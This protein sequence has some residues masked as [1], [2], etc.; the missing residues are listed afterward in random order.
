MSMIEKNILKHNYSI[1]F[2]IQLIFLSHDKMK[3][4]TYDEKMFSNSYRYKR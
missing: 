4:S 3:F 2:R 1:K